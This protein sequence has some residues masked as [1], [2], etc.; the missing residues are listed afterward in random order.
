MLWF[1]AEAVDMTSTTIIGYTLVGMGCRVG[2][3]SSICLEHRC[4]I[5]NW[6]A[7]AVRPKGQL[8]PTDEYMLVA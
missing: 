5:D 8:R 2:Y 7:L 3:S 4:N 1:G 6:R